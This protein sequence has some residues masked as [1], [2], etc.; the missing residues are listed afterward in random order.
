[1]MNNSF[2]AVHMVLLLC[3]AAGFACMAISMLRHQEDIFGKELSASA[4]RLLRL[5]GWLLLAA[6]LLVA[7]SAMGWSFGL[8]AYSGHTSAAAGGVFL[9]LLTYERCKQMRANK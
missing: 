9:A 8:T 2:W 3:C 7:V 4:T 6:A 1:M 5:A